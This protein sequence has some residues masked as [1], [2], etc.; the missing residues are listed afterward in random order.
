M[1][2]APGPGPAHDECVWQATQA[3][4]MGTLPQGKRCRSRSPGIQA[5]MPPSRRKGEA[6]VSEADH[7]DP[8]KSEPTPE[9]TPG[10]VPDGQSRRAAHAPYSGGGTG[11]GGAAPGGAVRR[12]RRN[13]LQGHGH[14]AS[15]RR[16]RIQARR[17]PPDAVSRP[18]GRSGLRFRSDHCLRLVVGGFAGGR[19]RH[20]GRRDALRVAAVA[21]DADLRRH[22]PGC[23]VVDQVT[24]RRTA[25]SPRSP[26]CTA[27]CWRAVSRHPR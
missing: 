10:A 13:R 17:Y 2:D 18:R 19:G 24:R 9:A 4:A 1:A 23:D 21:A 22:V 3:G 27:S 26:R 14:W 12:P 8:P 16:R 15:G 11:G 6:T 7:T 5:P 25:R 20:R